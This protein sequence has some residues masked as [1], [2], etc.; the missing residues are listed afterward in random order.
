MLPQ[1]FGFFFLLVQILSGTYVFRP[2][3]RLSLT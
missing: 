3:L 1:C 2:S